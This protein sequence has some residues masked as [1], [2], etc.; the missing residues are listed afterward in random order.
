MIDAAQIA[1]NITWKWCNRIVGSHFANG[2]KQTNG[3]MDDKFGDAEYRNTK[4]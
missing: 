3:K 4:K 1:R 2:M